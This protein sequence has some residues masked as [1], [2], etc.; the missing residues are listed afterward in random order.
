MRSK[1]GTWRDGNTF[2]NYNTTAGNVW[3][4]L[5]LDEAEN[6]IETD[7][8]LLEQYLQGRIGVG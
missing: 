1:K 3:H 4:D 6:R 5:Y 7:T 8:H 2:K